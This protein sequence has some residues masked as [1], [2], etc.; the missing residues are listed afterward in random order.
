MGS[1]LER[2][3]VVK[4]GGYLFPRRP[5]PASIESFAEV[6]RRAVG[7][8]FRLGIVA[9]GGEVARDYISAARALG[10][11]EGMCDLVGIAASRVN[12]RL[13]Q[14]ALR[15]LAP[16]SIPSSIEEGARALREHRVVVM[17]GVSPGQSTTAVGALLA[18]AAEAEAYVIATDVDGIYTADPKVEPSAKKYDVISAEEAL[19]MALEG[20]FWAGS[21]ALDPIALKVVL[22]SGLVAYFLD[23]RDPRNIE[24]AL[25]GGAVGTKIIGR[26]RR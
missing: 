16:P 17:G 10:A 2:R 5:D 25:E 11:S 24:R 8:G 6:V 13:L 21:Y 20:G 9:G 18:E 12:A 15:D 1:N 3:A 22:R 19:K 4:V 26:G 7:R 14:A 23:G